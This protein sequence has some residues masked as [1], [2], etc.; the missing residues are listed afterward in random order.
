MNPRDLARAHQEAKMAWRL[1]FRFSRKSP[2]ETILIIIN[3][4][5]TECQ[6][7]TQKYGARITRPLLLRNLPALR[8]SGTRSYKSIKRVSPRDRVARTLFDVAACK[9]AKYN[10]EQDVK[11]KRGERGRR[12]EYR[13]CTPRRPLC[14]PSSRSPFFFPAAAA[15]R[16]SRAYTFVVLSCP[17]AQTPPDDGDSPVA[18]AITYLTREISAR[19]GS[20]APSTNSRAKGAS[21]RRMPRRAIRSSLTPLLTKP[22]KFLF[23]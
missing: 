20:A 11:E 8:I 6:I 3:L 10:Y 2:R 17:S 14:P 22:T 12:E 19:A 16:V 18:G 9:S 1:L 21:A 7:H 13:R 4:S 23:N 15:P 5:S